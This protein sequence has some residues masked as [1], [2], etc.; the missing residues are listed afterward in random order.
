MIRSKENK[1]NQLIKHLVRLHPV[2]HLVRLHPVEHSVRIHPVAPY[3]A[4]LENFRAHGG[5][6]EKATSPTSA[7]LMAV[8]LV[9]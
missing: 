6:L 3:L 7:K 2:E 8:T 4:N 1:E 9:L 5:P